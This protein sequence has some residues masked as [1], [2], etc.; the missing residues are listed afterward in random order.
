VYINRIELIEV[1]DLRTLGGIIHSLNGTLSPTLNR[2]DQLTADQ[3]LVLAYNLNANRSHC[4]HGFTAY[5]R[6]PSKYRASISSSA[7]FCPSFSDE[8]FGRGSDVVFWLTGQN[9]V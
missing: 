6:I 1:S 2:C 5:A 4:H 3:Q 8:L 7:V 9:L